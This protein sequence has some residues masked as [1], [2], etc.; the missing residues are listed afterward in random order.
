MKLITLTI[1]ASFFLATAS[2]AAYRPE[3]ST[4][5]A[6]GGESF[7]QGN[8]ANLGVIGQPGII[9]S[10]T[11]GTYTANH[12]FLPVLG[13]GFKILYPIIA[14]DKGSISF[15]LANNSSA[16]NTLAISNTGGS[17]LSWSIAK[18]QGSEWLTATPAT[19]SGAITVNIRANSAG[20]NV[21]STYNDT[22]T[23]SGA[24]IEQTAQVQLS[25]TVTASATFRLTVTVVSTN[26]TK[27][28]GSINDGTGLIACINTGNNPAAGSGTCQADLV[29]GASITLMQSPD[30]NSTLATWS[31]AC[32]G[33]GNCG[34]TNIAADTA[35]TATFPYSFMAK[36]NSSGNGYESL[37]AA[38]GNAAATDTIKARAVTFIEGTAGSTFTFNSGK[39]ITLVGGLDV[40]YLPAS[41]YTT[42]QNVLKISSG[43]LNIKGGIK[44]HK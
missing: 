3:A 38:Y 18:N 4:F 14:V 37:L 11:S 30:S 10:S 36:V 13:D 7:V 9:G 28:G 31:G 32:S 26:A 33:T 35:V 44:I 8:H 12:G 5:S 1:L 29:P 23:I 43:R 16:S 27:G 6:G 40:Y 42:I 22:L 41:S 25:L 21:G 39:T 17:S 2:F 19:G 34:I 15:T 20:L 24:G